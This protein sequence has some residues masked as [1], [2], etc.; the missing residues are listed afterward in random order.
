[1]AFHHLHESLKVHAKFDNNRSSSFEDQ[2][3]NK[4]T[5]RRDGNGG[6]IS[7]YSRGHERSRKHKSRY[8]A[9]GHTFLPYALETTDILGIPY[10]Y[11]KILN[12]TWQMLFTFYKIMKSCTCG[13]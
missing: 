12:F 3:F 13:L 4:N 2:L 7:S 1:M 8:P 5:D 6:P 9:E 10:R 11:Y